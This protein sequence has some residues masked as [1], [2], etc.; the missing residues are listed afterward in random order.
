MFCILAWVG[1][2]T[3]SPGRPNSTHFQRLRMPFHTVHEF[4]ETWREQAAGT[5]KIF[6]ALS[7]ESLGQ[8]V[9]S[10]GRSLGFLAWHITK[11]LG[12]LPRTAGLRVD[13]PSE[14]APLPA[15]AAAI[16]ASYEQASASV[17]AAVAEQWTDAMLA[18]VIPMYGE[19]WTRSQALDS[20]IQ[21]ET[22][23]RGQMTVLMRQAG[24]KVPGVVGPAR[25]EWAQW[26]MPAPE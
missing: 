17:A 16:S 25:E 10:T 6:R 23:H 11:T 13:A 1:G 19:Q 22:H 21:H 20:L 9:E 24:L 26:N 12:E 14:D 15:T 8:R 4:L 5:M 2:W 7:N 3:A 18:E